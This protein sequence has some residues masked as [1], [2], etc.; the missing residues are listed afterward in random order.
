MSKI[1]NNYELVDICYDL[2]SVSAYSNSIDIMM[3][4]CIIDLMEKIDRDNYGTDDR[5]DLTLK[6]LV[7]QVG[8]FDDISDYSAGLC[9]AISAVITQK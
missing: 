2:N 4:D 7:D 9:D 1:L 5:K 6:V 8:V 3:K